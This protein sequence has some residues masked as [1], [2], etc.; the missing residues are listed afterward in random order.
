MKN[1]ISMG[2]SFQFLLGVWMPLMLGDR[3][4]AAETNSPLDQ[5]KAF[6]SSPPVIKNIHFQAKVPLDRGIGGLAEGFAL[7]K[8]YEYFQAAWQPDGVF[9]RR[10]NDPSDA[11]NWNV[12]GQL[13]S[14]FNHNH[15]L[16]ETKPQLTTWNDN[17]P[18]VK[19]KKIS[20]FYVRRFFL[21]PLREI[22]NLGIMHVDIGAV[23]WEGN[24]FHLESDDEEHFTI[25]GE[26][27]AS[28]NE[29]PDHLNVRYVFQKVTNDYILRYGYSP[30]FK[31]PFL[32]SAITNFWLSKGQE[33]A[34]DEWK[35]LNLETN[36]AALT[37]ASFDVTPF[38]ERHK[39]VVRIYTNGG[40]YERTT[41][42]NLRYL[43]L[44]GSPKPTLHS[45]GIQRIFLRILY[46][47]WIVLNLSIFTLIVRV[48]AR[49]QTTT[50]QKGTPCY[51]I[52]V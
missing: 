1:Q 16:V 34:F 9:F 23:H 22:L 4:L 31:Y 48:K 20:I 41:E 36:E 42:G 51:E 5:F 7:S 11:T 38:L 26:V 17:D 8:N 49:K 21:H 18:S 14:A 28:G 12:A 45:P 2:N 32:P 43:G 47:V 40:F 19:G 44:L 6:I 3:G 13:V 37:A 46:P 15:A 24:R 35:I 29:P 50:N 33:I 52:Q 27:F 10:L 30:A 25:N 39:W